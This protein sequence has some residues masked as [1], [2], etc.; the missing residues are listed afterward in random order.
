MTAINEVVKKKQGYTLHIVQTDKYKT[1]SLILKM[2]APLDQETVTLRGLLPHVMQSST[3][4]YPSTTELR[5]YLDELYGAN[6]FTDLGKKGEYHVVSMSV[7]IANEKFLRDSEPLLQ[8]G[9]EFLADV[10]Q[11]PHI[12]NNEFDK[13]TVEKEKRNQKVRI[14]AVYD[15]KMR[16]ANSRLVEEMCKGE[17]FA[18]HV[19]GISEEV[20]S[21][22]AKSLYEYY[23]KVMNEDQ[24]DLYVIGDV[25]VV[26]VEK[27]CDQLLQLK[28]RTPLEVDS[29][30]V[31]QKERENVVKE[32]QDVK[33]GKLNMGYRTHTQYGDDDYFALQVFNG[34]F[35]GFSHS[36]LFINVREKASLAYY[37]ASRLESHKGLLMV[38]SGIEFEKYDQAVGIINDQLQA[39]KDGDFTDGEIEQTKAV[40]RNQLL[41]TIDTSRGLVEVLYH[42]AVA[43]EE[44]DLKHWL[45]EIEK[46][47]KEDIVKAANK[48]ELDTIYFLTGMEG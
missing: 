35:G 1:N 20:E 29:S 14:Q 19:N 4:T 5:S 8:K 47:T 39:M 37:A 32:K 48:V 11:N 27:L 7:E 34:I 38:M 15:D 40:I 2:K 25:D 36:K 31:E 42:N 16:Y 46:T 33:Q 45:E 9:I 17:R 21:I 22:T 44:I 12:E 43:H 41:E 6:F 18:L 28:E 23:Q 30:E 26:E 24:F 13:K 10:L 3:K